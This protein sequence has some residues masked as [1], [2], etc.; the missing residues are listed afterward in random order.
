MADADTYN[1]TAVFNGSDFVGASTASPAASVTLTRLKPSVTINDPSATS[2]PIDGTVTLSATLVNLTCPGNSNCAAAGVFKFYLGDPGADGTGGQLIATTDALTGSEVSKSV[3]I[4]IATSPLASVAT[5]TGIHARYEPDANNKKLN[6]ANSAN[7]TSL[8]VK[9]GT[10]TITLGAPTRTTDAAPLGTDSL[11]DVYSITVAVNAGQTGV[12]A[13]TGGTVTLKANGTTVAT[14]TLVAGDAGSHTFES[15][16]TTTGVLAVP[17]LRLTFTAEYSGNTNLKNG[18]S[19]EDPERWLNL[20][21]ATPTVTLSAPSPV[22]LG[23]SVTLTVTVK[24]P[25]NLSVACNGCLHFE[26]VSGPGHPWTSPAV[27][28]LETV[29]DPSNGA[30]GTAELTFEPED[31]PFT[32]AGTWQLR[33]VYAGNAA[34]SPSSSPS[35]TL[36][37]RKATPT[38]TISSTNSPVT[39]GT[40]LSVTVT[41]SGS[42]VT[43][44]AGGTVTLLLGTTELGTVIVATNG[45]ASFTSTNA[46]PTGAST[47]LPASGAAYSVTA[48]FNGNALNGNVEQAVSP[49]EGVT[50]NAIATSVSVSA[51]GTGTTGVAVTLTANVSPSTAPGTIKFFADGTEVGEATFSGTQV[52]VQWTPATADTYTITA[53]FTSSDEDYADD[54]TS[55]STDI[56]VSDPPP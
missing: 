15:L 48:R 44:P 12:L 47:S 32:M 5:H 2:V 3:D 43:S 24:G 19:P 4:T 17:N 27:S 14:H 23:S 46:I 28:V 20:S 13:A 16:T 31:A 36:A 37:L 53:T 38:V 30:V 41:V 22:T 51:P 8:E 49:A 40:P 21:K 39:A 9:E 11:G 1:L 35:I 34:Y 18:T 56:L 29:N 33:A 7:T 10:P 55:N 42:G 45:T 26:S 6:A 50:V 52:S 54:P 25:P